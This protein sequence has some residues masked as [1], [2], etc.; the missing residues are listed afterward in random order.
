M[1]DDCA[2][3]DLLRGTLA[4][5]SGVGNGACPKDIH[6]IRIATHDADS[7]NSARKGRKCV[8]QR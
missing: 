1:I 7:R 6:S 3:C 4:S 2:C 8:I 5:D